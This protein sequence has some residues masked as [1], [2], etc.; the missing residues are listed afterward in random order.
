MSDTK[1]SGQLPTTKLHNPPKSSVKLLVM[2]E[3]GK[4]HSRYSQ[5]LL[6]AW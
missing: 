5:S 1:H 2:L 4:C 6:E 3:D